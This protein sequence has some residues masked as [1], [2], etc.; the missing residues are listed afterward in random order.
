M[1][2]AFVGDAQRGDAND[3]EEAGRGFPAVDGG[4]VM[5]VVM[6]AVVVVV[7]VLMMLGRG[8]AREEAAPASLTDSRRW[9]GEEMRRPVTADGP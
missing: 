8:G 7:K 1:L 6:V 5:V 9:L 3:A 2:A 4:E